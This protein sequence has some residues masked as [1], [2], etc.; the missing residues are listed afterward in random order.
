MFAVFSVISAAAS[1]ADSM[2]KAEFARMHMDVKPVA[3]WKK[4]EIEI[5]ALKGASLS[6]SKKYAR[7]I[8]DLQL[9]RFLF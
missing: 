5:S 4:S 6:A 8:T 3:G 2:N 9:S 1:F 7:I